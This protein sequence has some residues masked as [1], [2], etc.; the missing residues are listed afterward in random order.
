MYE[1]GEGGG[2]H[3]VEKERRGK[4]PAKQ[5]FQSQTVVRCGV[6][7]THHPTRESERMKG[8]RGAGFTLSYKGAGEKHKTIQN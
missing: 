5:N 7:I 2:E 8:W 1:R 4:H 3:I 6:S